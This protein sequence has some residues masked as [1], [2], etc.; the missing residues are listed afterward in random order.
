MKVLAL[1]VNSYLP[2]QQ[3]IKY[4]KKN[5]HPYISNKNKN[6]ILIPISSYTCDELY[7]LLLSYSVQP[8]CIHLVKDICVVRHIS[9]QIEWERLCDE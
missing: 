3:L 8:I 4:F 1:F 2:H 6:H 9:D 5:N 7:K